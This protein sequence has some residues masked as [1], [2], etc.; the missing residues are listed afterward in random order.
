MQNMK[1]NQIRLNPPEESDFSLFLYFKLE[2]AHIISIE[3]LKL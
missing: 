2:N 1:E 3:L